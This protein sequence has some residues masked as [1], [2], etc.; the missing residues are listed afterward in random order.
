[1]VVA[2]LLGNAL[3]FAL[4]PHLPPA[5]QHSSSLFDLGTVV[6]FWLCLVIYGLLELGAS[7]SRHQGGDRERK[8]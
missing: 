7:L 1:M 5:A 4:T 3:Y 8:Q 2:I 6:D